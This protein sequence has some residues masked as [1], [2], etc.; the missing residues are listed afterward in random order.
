[1]SSIPSSLTDPISSPAIVRTSS[2]PAQILCVRH[3]EKQRTGNELNHQGKERAKELVKFFTTDSRVLKHGP[4]G[5]LCAM[6]P[7]GHAG[8]VR[9]IETLEPLA[10]KLGLKIHAEFQKDETK[11]LVRSILG[12]LKWA[13]KSVVVSWEHEALLDVVKH[14]GVDT[15]PCPKEWPSDV[16]DLVLII[17]IGDDGKPTS[18]EKIHQDLKMDRT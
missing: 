11:S 5:G 15:P 7:N 1:M 14:F 17:D 8:S 6:R 4:P 12:N 16:Y 3:G 13:G 2:Y 18:F 9:P 10:D